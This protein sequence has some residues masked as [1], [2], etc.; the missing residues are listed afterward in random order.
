M[1]GVWTSGALLYVLLLLL[2]LMMSML[3]R[4]KGNERVLF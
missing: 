3:L 1:L 2:E 4:A